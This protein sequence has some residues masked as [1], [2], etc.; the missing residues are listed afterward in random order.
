MSYIP[1]IGT[2]FAAIKDSIL[3][4]SFHVQGPLENATITPA[5]LNLLTE[6][7]FSALRIPQRMLTLPGEE[8]K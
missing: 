8:K 7:F 5:P 2:G 6:F 3:V 4:A 1:L